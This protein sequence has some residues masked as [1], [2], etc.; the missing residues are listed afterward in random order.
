MLNLILLRLMPSMLLLIFLLSLS[1]LRISLRLIN[2]FTLILL[3][4]LKN[5]MIL[6]SLL[7][8][9][10]KNISVLKWLLCYQQKFKSYHLSLQ[11]DNYHIFIYF[12]ILISLFITNHLLFI[13]FL[14]LFY[15]KIYYFFKL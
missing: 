10:N 9:R 15:F 3:M 12:I 14:K 5:P 1:M 13:I 6:L 8:S 11:P 4:S 7:I 2:G